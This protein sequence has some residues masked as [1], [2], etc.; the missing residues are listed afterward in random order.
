MINPSQT[1]RYAKETAMDGQVWPP[2]EDTSRPFIKGV[3][4]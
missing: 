2:R 4:P 3:T 1:V